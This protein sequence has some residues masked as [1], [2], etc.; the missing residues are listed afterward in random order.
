[1]AKQLKLLGDQG[2]FSTMGSSNIGICYLLTSNI[3]V[4]TM[5]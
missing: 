4:H 2:S 3:N 5:F 1:M